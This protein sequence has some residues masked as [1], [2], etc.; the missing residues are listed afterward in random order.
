MI[1]KDAGI[2]RERHRKWSKEMLEAW[3]G[4]YTAIVTPF[5]SDGS[6]DEDGLRK[7]VDFQV[8]GGVEGLV[9]CGTTGESATMSLE[10]QKKVVRTVLEQV[11]GR[12]LVLAGAGG[13]S[14]S[15]VTTHAREMESLG[16]DGIL[17]VVP[18]YNKPTQEGMYQ[19]FSRVADEVSIPIIL[20]NVPSRTGSNMLPETAL[21]LAEHDNISGIK[22]AS[23]N[24]LQV[25]EIIKGA[26][27]RFR[28][29]SGEDN[30]TFS[31]LGLGGDGVISVV[32]NEVPMMMSRMVRDGLAGNWDGAR[33]LHYRLLGLMNVNFVE[34]N[35]IPAKAALVMMG[36]I[37]ENY[38]LPLVP[39]KDESRAKLR[40]EL[41]TLELISE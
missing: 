37:E 6:I 23:G 32:A 16:A 41:L 12:V 11:E 40:Q 15:Q 26:P 3:K 27:E 13:N 22:E 29:L 38:R 10:E 5:K 4:T 17:S 25:M 20:Y 18:Y 31:L 21:R 8:D 35:P 2:R 1:V 36:L 33:R 30:L 39:M 7:L 19:H 9:P 24:L 14:T 28:V 34:T